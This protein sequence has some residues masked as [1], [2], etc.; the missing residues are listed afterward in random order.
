MAHRYQIGNR[1]FLEVKRQRRRGSSQALPDFADRQTIQTGFH[2]Q[3]EDGQP[4]FVRQGSKSGKDMFSFHISSIL[5][6][7]KLSRV[8]T[9]VFFVALAILT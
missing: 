2:Q 8:P 6:L 5:E 3:P 1:Q 4:G 7:M 9:E